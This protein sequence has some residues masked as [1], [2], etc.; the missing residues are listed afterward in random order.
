MWAYRSVTDPNNLFDFTVSPHRDGAEIFSSGFE[1][2]IYADGYAGYE[3][4]ELGSFGTIRRAACVA[5]ARWP[6]LEI[7]IQSV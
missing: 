6:A 5:H 4:I 3:S 2:A 1:G 7:L